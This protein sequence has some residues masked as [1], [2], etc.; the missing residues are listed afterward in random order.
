MA[1]EG[2]IVHFV[3]PDGPKKLHGHCRNAVVARHEEQGL[4]SDLL[5]FR[6]PKGRPLILSGDDGEGELLRAA[7]ARFRRGVHYAHPKEFGTWHRVSECAT[8]VE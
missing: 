1:Y 3:L 7:G 4:I 6:D 5:V 8:I 2:E